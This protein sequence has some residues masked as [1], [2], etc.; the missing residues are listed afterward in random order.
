MAFRSVPL[1]RGD[2]LDMLR[3]LRGARTLDGVRGR[4]PAGVDA[5]VDAL[6][7]LGR[8]AAEAGHTL[9]ALDIDPVVVH[10]A[11]RGVTVIDALVMVEGRP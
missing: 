7:A 2:A 8:L 10:A 4:G 9:A 11:G 1:T 3:S 5:V 6:L